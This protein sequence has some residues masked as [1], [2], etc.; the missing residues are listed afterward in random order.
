[1]LCGVAVMLVHEARKLLVG[2]G[3]QRETATAIQELAVAQ[4]GVRRA[5]RPL[6][7]YVGADEVLLALDVEFESGLPARQIAATVDELEAEIRRRYP[8]I[9]RIYIEA[10]VLG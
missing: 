2:E 6:S 4:P 3:L 7:M 1:L 9:K 10:R 5:S 8:R